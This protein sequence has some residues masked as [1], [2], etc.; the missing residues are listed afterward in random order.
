[1]NSEENDKGR[2]QCEVKN[3]KGTVNIFHD[4]DVLIKY[5]WIDSGSSSPCSKTCG[6]GFSTKKRTCY[7][8]DTMQPVEKKCKGSEIQTT[9]CLIRQCPVINY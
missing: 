4:V 5:D 9:S 6:T 2:Y 8:L 7:R 1:M 3:S